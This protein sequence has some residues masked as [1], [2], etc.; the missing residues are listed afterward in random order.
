MTSE[1]DRRFAAVEACAA[2][3]EGRALEPG[4]CD[5]VQLAAHDIRRMGRATPLLKGL[6]Y[7]GERGSLRAFQKLGLTD[8]TE[9]MDQMGFVR[10]APLMTW[11]ADI[12]ALPAPFEGPFRAS[13]SVVAEYGAGRTL[14][15]GPDMRCA[16]GVPDPRKIIAAWRIG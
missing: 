6:R 1:T 15:F 12:V 3:F 10:I 2:R 4:V 14:A 5:C 9:A 8:L 11:A 7:R 16:I 13:L